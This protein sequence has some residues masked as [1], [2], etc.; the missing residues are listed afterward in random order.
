[1]PYENIL[2][3]IV[4]LEYERLSDGRF[5]NDSLRL[6]YGNI[7]ERFLNDN[8]IKAERIPKSCWLKVCDYRCL[9]VAA[10]I[11][12]SHKKFIVSI[13]GNTIMVYYSLY[14]K[15]WYELTGEQKVMHTCVCVLCFVP[16]QVA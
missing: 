15:L 3:E 14:D 8:D 13:N 16:D 9:F 10:L 4:Q 12:G 6:Y 11:V 5:L 2:S 1:M 7:I